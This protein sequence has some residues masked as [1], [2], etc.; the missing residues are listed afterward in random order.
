MDE[1]QACMKPSWHTTDQFRFKGSTSMQAVVQAGALEASEANPQQLGTELKPL[2]VFRLGAQA[3]AV[4]CICL[5]VSP[6]EA[7]ELC[8][9]CTAPNHE[10]QTP[11][12]L[13]LRGLRRL[14]RP[15]RTNQT[16]ISR[17]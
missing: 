17:P 14:P 1:E 9:P 6:L 12:R 13:G 7:T 11:D 16:L 8:T 2:K 3:V 4:S 10:S 15:R 5:P